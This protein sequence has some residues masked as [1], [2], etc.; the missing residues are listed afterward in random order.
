MRDFQLTP[1]R[2]GEAGVLIM[3]K[4]TASF[5]LVACLL[6]AA[7]ASGAE[8]LRISYS[9]PSIS[10]ALL[11]VTQEA[12]LFEKNG[13]EVEVLYLAGS[14]GQ[15]ALI[16]GET[17]FAVYTG[18][19]MT[20]ARLQGADVVMLASFL[21][22]LLSRLVVRP[23]IKSA[24]ELKAK[25]LGVTRFGTA[26]DFGMRL[27]LAKLGLNPDSDVSIL[28]IG[29]NPTRL[30][31]LQARSI[32][33]AIFDPPEYKKAVEAGGRVLFNMEETPIPYQHA[34]LIS[35]RKQISAR[36]DTTRRVVRAIVEGAA[37]VRRD[38]VVSKRALASRLRMKDGPELEETYQLLRRFTQPKPY[39]SIEG[40]QAILND[41]S[42]RMPAAKNANPREFSDPRWIEELERD[43]T[44][45]GL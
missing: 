19:L 31:A 30:L 25:R 21:D 11:W 7:P 8:K 15:S 18:L 10:N 9:G 3:K 45:D 39:P 33:G 43:G 22:H 26:S 2:G 44:I 38:P 6:A 23:E 24:A 37:A 5:L 34:G 32:D 1:P 27:M 42:K 16:A 41:L 17:Q 36:P 14:L 28:Q 12:K 4:A 40:F 20:P 35:T 13:L 29:D